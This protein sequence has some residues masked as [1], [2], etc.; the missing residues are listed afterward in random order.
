MCM[1]KPFRKMMLF[2]SRRS[3]ILLLACVWMTGLILGV[4]FSAR[5]SDSYFLLMRTAASSRV[6]IAGLIASAYLPFL[7]SAFAVLIGKPWLLYPLSLIKALASG[8]GFSGAALAFGSAGWLAQPLLFFTDVCLLPVLCWF[9]IRHIG[10]AENSLK[11]DFF[12]CTA[13]AVLVGCLDYCVV[14]PFLAM[15]ID[16]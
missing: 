13:A 9:M 7:F 14:S 8:F 5:S 12:L 1:D 4:F 6:S 3:S 15:L 10:G 11:R 16:H 2:V